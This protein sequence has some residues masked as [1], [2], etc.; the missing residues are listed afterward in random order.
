MYALLVLGVRSL[1]TIQPA[2][3]AG[4]CPLHAGDPWRQ[5]KNDKI[6]SLKIAQLLKSGMFPL[7]YTYPE[8]MRATRDL[9]RRRMHLMR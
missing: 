6:D 8:P 4:A 9:L 2:V 5:A 7:A 1:P 3:C